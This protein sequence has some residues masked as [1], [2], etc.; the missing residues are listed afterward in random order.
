MLIPS[1]AAGI[2]RL[3][4]GKMPGPAGMWIATIHP[5]LGFEF[6][7]MRPLR[8]SARGRMP[9]IPLPPV[10]PAVSRSGSPGR[11]GIN[12]IAKRWSIIVHQGIEFDARLRSSRIISSR[13]PRMVAVSACENH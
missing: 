10:L 4:F 13:P 9:G 7:C 8:L 6:N 3:V 5:F 2:H 1:S 11:K 12:T